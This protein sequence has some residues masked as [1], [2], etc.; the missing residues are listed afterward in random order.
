MR[1]ARTVRSIERWNASLECY[2]TRCKASLIQIPRLRTFCTIHSSMLVSLPKCYSFCDF[3][4]NLSYS[5]L[6]GQVSQH[7]RPKTSKHG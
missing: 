5:P 7:H 1:C 2:T 6:V 3:M 4:S